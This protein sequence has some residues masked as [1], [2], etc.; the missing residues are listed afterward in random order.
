MQA[1]ARRA[2]TLV[3]MLVVIAVIAAL[4]G[5]LLVGL[6]AA[7]RASK[8]TRQMADLTQLVKAWTQYA[9]T[10]GDSILPGYLEEG[11]QTA[12]KVS[13]KYKDGTKIPPEFCRT[14]PWRLLPY[15]DHS[16]ATLYEYLDVND[17]ELQP[18]NFDGTPNT[19][20]MQIV[21]DQPAF[22]YNAY[23]LGGWWTQDLTNGPTMA[24]SNSTWQTD[25]GATAKG[26]VVATKLGSVHAPSDMIVFAA[27]TFR[28]PGFYNESK[29]TNAT[30]GSA[31]VVP[32]VLADQTIWEPSDGSSFSG[33]TVGAN[34]ASAGVF[35]PTIGQTMT[36]GGNTGMNV[37]VAQGVPLRRFG[38]SVA[39]AHVDGSVLGAGLGE[40]ENQRLWINAAWKAAPPVNSFTHSQN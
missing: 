29:D 5:I 2:F 33:V 40:L 30:V 22:G 34:A 37:L 15:L 24:F 4:M 10:Y 3:E 8:R 36:V 1:R 19:T 31:W 26:L 20:G 12:W 39:V 13:Y 6:Q 27:S 7:Q 35:Q 17:D 21:S 18:K 16:F 32:H 28:T 11:V 9:G 14:Y 23:Y 38:P 25:A